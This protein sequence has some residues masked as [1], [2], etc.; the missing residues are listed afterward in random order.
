[1]DLC[2]LDYDPRVILQLRVLI[3]Q[4]KKESLDFG[5]DP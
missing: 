4:V 1:M 2:E 3:Y 5:I